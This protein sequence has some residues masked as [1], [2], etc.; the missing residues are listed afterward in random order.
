MAGTQKWKW[1]WRWFS[2]LFRGDVDVPVG[3]G[4]VIHRLS[5]YSTNTT[6]TRI[7]TNSPPPPPPPP[8]HHHHHHHHYYYYYYYYYYHNMTSIPLAVPLGFPY[9]PPQ[10][11]TKQLFPIPF[12]APKKQFT[13]TR[14][15]IVENQSHQWSVKIQTERFVFFIFLLNNSLG[16]PR[17]LVNRL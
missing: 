3:F 8:S 13:S 15:N 1:K 12:V 5:S 11:I 9:P 14:T 7:C 6:A 17:K 16:C 4:G 2:S 10:T